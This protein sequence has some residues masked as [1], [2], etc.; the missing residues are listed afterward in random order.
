MRK[1]KRLKVDS[2][3]D[4]DADENDVNSFDSGIDAS[5]ENWHKSCLADS[6]AGKIETLHIINFM[7]HSNL[8]VSFNKRITFVTGKNGSGK[9]AIMAALVAAFG[10]SAS[11]T[12]RGVG[13]TDFI[14]KGETWAK[15]SV[16]FINDGINSYR[17]DI[18][19]KRIT[20]VRSI[21]KN[22]AST[23]TCKSEFGEVVSKKKDE[24]DRICTALDIQIKN[25][26]C[27]LNQDVARSFLSS[28]DSKM[29]YS[30]FMQATHLESLK[31]I[32]SETL[33]LLRISQNNLDSKKLGI[34]AANKEIRQLKE[35]LEYF[36]SLEKYVN[37][38]TTLENEYL[39]SL[40]CSEEK[41]LEVLQ[42][43]QKRIE[44]KKEECV[45]GQVNF[46]S[47]IEELENNI[48][49]T[50]EK[51][52][53]LGRNQS[54][55]DKVKKK[56]LQ[57]EI[58]NLQRQINT[59]SGHVKQLVT[60]CDRYQSDINSIQEHLKQSE[61]AAT[62]SQEEKD[63]IAS[64]ISKLK[65]D[66][67]EVRDRIKAAQRDN[68]NGLETKLQYTLTLENLKSDLNDLELSKKNLERQI[69]RTN[70][71]DNTLL[72]YGPFAVTLRDAIEE[73]VKRNKFQK[74][75]VGPCG[76]YVTLTG[77]SK[78]ARAVES[79][80]GGLMNTYCCDNQMDFQV[81][82]RIMD[83]VCGAKNPPII[84]SKF[85]NTRHNVESEKVSVRGA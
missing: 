50:K 24:I 84:I 67:L 21:S 32:Y 23:Y 69:E 47:V 78:W 29:R 25:P 30:L 1:H 15:V 10:G 3:A 28:T 57:A 71:G 7:C 20:I 17:R 48:K 42:E 79:V 64:Q 46:Q 59:A 22:A 33:D 11:T 63:K 80:V 5:D 82:S 9:S 2:N 43:E 6:F 62:Q 70:V 35:K 75:P 41:S 52:S 14:K 77:D 53:N 54:D 44:Q 56:D 31:T 65:E 8:E 4:H 12:G 83:K 68:D 38:R 39:W 34:S 36:A 76:L 19:G 81:L 49:E 40:V 66:L 18:Y 27:I 61:E 51:L 45:E 37:E 26:I 73:A 58:Q 55:E 85:Q 16:T 13:I 74:K 72:K 60:K